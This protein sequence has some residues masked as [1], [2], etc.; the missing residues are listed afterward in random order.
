M[1][2]ARLIFDLAGAVA[3]V[4]AAVMV[5]HRNPIKSLL[6][7]VVSFFALAAGFVLLS[8]PFLAAIQV[9]VY[10]GAILVLFLFVTMLL[11]LQTEEETADRRPFQKLFALVGIVALAA[12][13]LSDVRRSGEITGTSGQ[14]P[15]TGA[16][17][18]LARAL[19]SQAALPFEA[20]SVLLL[21]SLTGAY[22]LMRRERSGSAAP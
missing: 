7:I 19:F 18:P 8:A 21:A 11:N 1:N 14:P 9:I 13:L 4:F 15:A 22:V 12:I 20:V 10:A 6:A 5:V 16:V 2:A 3:F 17:E